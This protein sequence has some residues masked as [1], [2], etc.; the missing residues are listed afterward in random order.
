MFERLR[1]W[2]RKALAKKVVAS[3][4]PERRVR[5]EEVPPSERFII[6]IV[7]MVVFFVG[8]VTIEIVYMIVFR[9]WNEIVFNGIMLLVG[10]LIGALF[11]Y[12]EAP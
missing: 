2:L 10:S 3:V 4:G 1:S 11:G 6:S 7:L 5:Y 12:R 9:E 8:L